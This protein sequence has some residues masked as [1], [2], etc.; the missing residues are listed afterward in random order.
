MAIYSS[1]S[2]LEWREVEGGQLPSAT[3][4]SFGLEATLLDQTLYVSGGS[5]GS[6][7]FD[8]S[9]SIL[10]W[11]PIAG[12]GNQLAIWLLGEATMQP[13]PFVHQLLRCGMDASKRS[14]FNLICQTMISD[15][16]PATA[17]AEIL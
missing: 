3:V 6:P 1:S 5:T 11:D 2:Q 15:S 16:H 12:F 10:S 9:T 7:D 8:Y 4:W 17:T 14:E 13:L